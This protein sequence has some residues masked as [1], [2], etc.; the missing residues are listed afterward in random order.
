MGL[1]CDTTCGVGTRLNTKT[2]K[3][4]A[5]NFKCGPGTEMDE[6][7]TQCVRSKNLPTCVYNGN[8]KFDIQCTID[9]HVFT[10]FEN[11]DMVDKTSQKKSQQHCNTKAAR[12]SN[13]GGFGTCGQLLRNIVDVSTTDNKQCQLF[14]NKMWP[15][16]PHFSMPVQTVK[17]PSQHTESALACAKLCERTSDCRAFDYNPVNTMCTLHTQMAYYPPLKDG[18][19]TIG[20]CAKF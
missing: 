16:H 14:H 12:G 13:P 5:I 8:H 11:V 10:V 2:Q 6:K 9:N 1:Q 3:C 15:K 17:E 7:K 18:D 4:D 19:H 20:S